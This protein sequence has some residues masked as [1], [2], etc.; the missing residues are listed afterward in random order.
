M[1]IRDDEKI[2]VV[3]PAGAA[4]EVESLALL[5]VAWMVR[6]GPALSSVSM[7]CTP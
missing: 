2:R 5:V 6:I 3:T 1:S 7:A 4:G